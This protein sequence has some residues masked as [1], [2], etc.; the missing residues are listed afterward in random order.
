MARSKE[1]IL[2]NKNNKS[3][4]YKQ[5]FADGLTRDSISNLVDAVIADNEDVTRLDDIVSK[6]EE[7]PSLKDTIVD[8]IMQTVESGDIVTLDALESAL[9]AVNSIATVRK[10]SINNMQGGEIVGTLVAAN[11]QS[12]LSSNLPGFEGNIPDMVALGGRDNT[13]FQ[14][15]SVVP[16]STVGMGNFGAGETIT[17]V[18][19][20]DT[21]ASSEREEVQVFVQNTLTYTF[22]AKAK[23]DDA[24][25]YPL[26]RG[27]NE[28]TIGSTG[29]EINDYEVSTTEASASR[30]ITIDGIT[31]TGTFDYDAGTIVLDVSANIPENT[32]IYFSGALSTKNL[33][34]ISGTVGVEIIDHKYTSKTVV[35]NVTANSLDTRRVL[36]S[37]RLNIMSSSMGVAV[38]K[39][40]EEMKAKKIDKAVRFATPFGDV[41][42][43]TAGGSNYSAI[44]SQYKQFNMG[45]E[46]ARADITKTSQIT[47]QVAIV[48]GSALVNVISAL[49]DETEGSAKV[50]TDDNTSFRLLGMI[51]GIYPAYFDPRH[52]LKYPKDGTKTAQID[53]VNAITVA[54]STAYTLTINGVVATYTSDAD[55]TMAEITLGLVDAINALSEPVTA[56]DGAGSFTITSDIAGT[57]FTTVV[58]AG[59]MTATTTTEN[60]DKKDEDTVFIVGTPSDPSKRAVISGTGLPILPENLSTDT[61]SNK[62]ISLQGELVCETNK[63]PYSRKLARKIK[64]KV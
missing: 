45:V 15:L 62:T 59:V 37:G 34:E 60:V 19:A 26:E 10:D 25:N 11:I 49:T 54:N 1:E 33:G 42:D 64:I 28:I 2:A 24:S 7:V 9:S 12:I 61:N 52:D 14:V 5:A 20:S 30:I 43:L 40:A 18:N 63:D 51:N 36:Q 23:F 32:N 27:K 22:N 48:G 8:S 55:A 21:M 38:N 57:P 31:Y 56:T 3:Q 53:T 6:T 16:V 58:T 29:V 41:I 35:L 13:K 50:I 39:I 46:S 4:Y 47:S 17:S 44:V